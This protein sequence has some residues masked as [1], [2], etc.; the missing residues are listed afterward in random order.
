MSGRHII[1][2]A[3]VAMELMPPKDDAG[4]C[5]GCVADGDYLLCDSLP[6]CEDKV[7]GVSP[8]RPAEGHH[9]DPTGPQEC[10]SKA[11]KPTHGG[12]PTPAI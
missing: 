5:S 7:W 6:R 2:R 4:C 12:Y 10:P 3:G 8:V 11:Y 1:I 9:G